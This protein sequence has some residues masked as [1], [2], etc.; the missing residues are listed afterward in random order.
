MNIQTLQ[1]LIA[2]LQVNPRVVGIVR[3]GCRCPD[4]MSQG[5]DFDLF[6]FL[7]E[8]PT[9]LESIHFYLSDIPVD[10]S[11]R[12]LDDLN[13][14]QPISDIDVVLPR[15]DIL[16]DPTNVLALTLPSLDQKWNRRGCALTEHEIHSNRF[17]QQH[18]LDKVKGRLEDQPLFCEFLLTTNVFWLIQTY[19]RVRSMVYPGEKEAL[20]WLERHEPGIYGVIEDFYG[21]SDLAEKLALSEQLTDWVLSPIGRWKKGEVLAFGVH[22][23]ATDLETKAREIFTSLLSHEVKASPG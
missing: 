1:E 3:Y 19:F 6:V 13:Q 7:D 10:M 11:L 5:G 4:D 16:Y 12:T 15:A 9:D 14:A 22:P 21:A 2:H 17:C 23:D 20:T 18:V 8:R